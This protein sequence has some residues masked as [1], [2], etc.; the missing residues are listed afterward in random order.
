MLRLVRLFIVTCMS[1]LVASAACS[2]S[3]ARS[4]V[5]LKQVVMSGCFVDKKSCSG[6]G[7]GGRVSRV[8]AN[9]S[10][11]RLA[12]NVEREFDFR[13]VSMRERRCLGES[14]CISMRRERIAF[15]RILG[16]VFRRR[17]FSHKTSSS[18]SR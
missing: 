16:I 7:P 10:S 8:L 17:E 5:F 14:V 2:V 3:L 12:R 15:W 13:S 11:H 4:A 18:E 9:S 1:C 6:V